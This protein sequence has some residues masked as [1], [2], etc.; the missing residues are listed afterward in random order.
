ML[1]IS[2]WMVDSQPWGLYLTPVSF[3]LSGLVYG[4]SY[5]GQGLGS[6][7][8]LELRSFVERAL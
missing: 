3:I 6:L 7:Q 1:G 2:Q 5:V 4:A 8:M